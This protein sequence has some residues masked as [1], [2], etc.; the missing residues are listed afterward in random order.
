[1]PTDLKLLHSL[2]ENADP[3]AKVLLQLAQ[4]GADLAKP[5]EPDFALIIPSEAD[6]Q[7]AAGRLSG[8]GFSVDVYPCDEAEDGFWVVAKKTMVL[9]LAVLQKLSVQLQQLAEEYGGDYDGW[10]AEV[11]E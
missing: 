8:L 11:V 7:L 6:A 10:G 4:H 9:E 3:D 2:K 1:M 5:H